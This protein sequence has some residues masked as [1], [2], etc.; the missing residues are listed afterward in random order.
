VLRGWVRHEQLVNH[1]KELVKVKWFGEECLDVQLAQ[2][3]MVCRGHHNDRS[4]Q[5]TC[6]RPKLTQEPSAVHFWQLEIEQDE[7][8]ASVAC[9]LQR[10]DARFGAND[11]MPAGSQGSNR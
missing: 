2:G 7:V 4:I 11:L 1:I 6:Q 5:A 10:L 9:A 8:W 3:H